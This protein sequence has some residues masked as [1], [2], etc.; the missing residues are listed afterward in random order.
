MNDLSQGVLLASTTT[1]VK[2]DEFLKIV[3]IGDQIK[4]GDNS[5]ST[6]TRKTY[7]QQ[8]SGDYI[9]EVASKRP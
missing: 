4:H 3:N 8:I 9:I 1:E 7:V 2:R 5:V 6:V